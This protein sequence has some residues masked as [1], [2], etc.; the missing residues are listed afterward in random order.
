MRRWAISA[1]IGAIGTAFV[2][3]TGCAALPL[4]T[5]MR[6]SRL[7]MGTQVTITAVGEESLRAGIDAAFAHMQALSDEMN[8]YDPASRVS[9]INRAAGVAPVAVSPDLM[10]V[11][12]Q[13]QG[14]ATRTA[15]AFDITIGAL[16][17]WR[18]SA[19]APR[20]PTAEE[21]RAGL[22]HVGFRDLV[23]DGARG[24]AFL[25]RPGMRIDLGGIAKLYIVDAGL[26]V[27]RERGLAR[28]M[29][30]A[31]GDIAV[32]GGSDAR[33]WRVGI[34]DPRAPGLVAVV[35]LAAGF[36]VSS[37]DYERFFIKD[38][39]RYHH[40][41]DPRNGLPT[42]GLRH[43]TLVSES[44]AS[45]NGLSAA[46]MVLG[47]DAARALIEATPGVQGLLIGPGYRWASGGFPFATDG[48]ERTMAKD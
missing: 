47:A 29:I 39:R 9:A 22:A 11:L 45:V 21:L 10:T 31:G 48:T 34:R 24:T 33:P 14:L 40:I 15:G 26:R 36:V 7:L 4:P 35:E 23:L 27:L 18:F 41:L 2:F 46:A 8:H 38:G 43:V 44:V 30:D 25:R 28:A 5:E 32:F 19:D 6:D 13:A 37:G 12:Q 16:T 3:M 17:G 20:I 1:C 42:A